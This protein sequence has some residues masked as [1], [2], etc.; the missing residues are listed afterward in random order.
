M[1]GSASFQRAKT[2]IY[3]YGLAM[4]EGEGGQAGRGALLFI[5]VIRHRGIL[6]TVR[7]GPRVLASGS[8][9]GSTDPAERN[10]GRVASERSLSGSES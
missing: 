2:H 9:I 1:S 4:V 8:G 6:R 3:R 7:K 10:R 5:H